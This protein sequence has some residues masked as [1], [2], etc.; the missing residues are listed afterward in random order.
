[1]FLFLSFLSLP[2]CFPDQSISE[3]RIEK[4][5]WELWN[6][7][8][9][10]RVIKGLL[11]KL[12]LFKHIAVAQ[13]WWGKG[14]ADFYLKLVL[15]CSTYVLLS[16]LGEVNRPSR[17]CS[18]DAS[19]QLDAVV[20]PGWAFASSLKGLGSVAEAVNIISVGRGTCC[21]PCFPGC[22][23]DSLLMTYFI[24]AYSL[25]ANYAR[26]FVW[27]QFCKNPSVTQICTDIKTPVLVHYLGEIQNTWF[28]TR[29]YVLLSEASVCFTSLSDRT[30]LVEVLAMKIC[31]YVELTIAWP[32][33]HILLQVSRCFLMNFGSD[34]KM[35]QQR[36]YG[37]KER[38]CCLW[39]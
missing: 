16:W 30:F 21:S 34:R 22:V 2:A 1:M 7:E 39:R 6:E 19:H 24:L 14:W 37:K 17:T 10:C 8:W 15:K 35:L 28:L 29:D 9:A 36:S 20:R 12:L 3:K 31:F 13:T 38:I 11:E 23:L 25:V 33:K 18:S 27:S 4:D 5:P 26:L 32:I